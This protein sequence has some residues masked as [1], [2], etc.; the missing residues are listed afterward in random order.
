VF[1]KR[2]IGDISDASLRFRGVPHCLADFSNEWLELP[3]DLH[4]VTV[5]VDPDPG[6]ERGQ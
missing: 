5:I 4:L 2:S 6:E 3:L 1:G